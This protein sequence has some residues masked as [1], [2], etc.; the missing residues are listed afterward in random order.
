MPPDMLCFPFSPSD[1]YHSNTLKDAR[2]RERV[3][4][5]K[6]KLEGV[7]REGERER[8]TFTKQNKVEGKLMKPVDLVLQNL[9]SHPLH[10]W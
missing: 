6:R 4:T 8:E 7:A 9:F 3:Q 10:P 2:E 5:Q 1:I